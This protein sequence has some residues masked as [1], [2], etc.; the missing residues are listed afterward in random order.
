MPNGKFPLRVAKYLEWQRTNRTGTNS[1]KIG[2]TYSGS[3]ILGLT[4]V[5]DIAKPGDK[6]LV[7]SYGSGSGSDAFIFTAT[8]KIIAAQKAKVKTT[9]DYVKRKEYLTYPEYEAHME[10]IH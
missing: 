7:T 10:Q 3:S 9:E 4:C 8:E 6:I 2:N 5:L 1:K